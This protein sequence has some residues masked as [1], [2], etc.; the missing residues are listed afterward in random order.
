MLLEQDVELQQRAFQTGSMFE[1]YPVV[2]DFELDL[3]MTDLL[4]EFNL[5]PSREE[6]DDIFAADRDNSNC[7]ISK[8]KA[9]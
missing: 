6:I 3:E 7:A 5:P 1:R 4:D 2:D 8:K 9:D